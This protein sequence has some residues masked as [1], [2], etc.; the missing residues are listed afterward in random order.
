MLILGFVLI[1][2]F[3]LG[4]LAFFV[5][6]LDAVL[7]GHDLPTSREAVRAFNDLV[8]MHRPDA[9]VVYDLGAGRGT[10]ALRLNEIAPALQIHAVDK[11]PIRIWIA[12]LKARWLK[13]NV[14]FIRGDI[15]KADLHDAD[16]VYTYLWYSQMPP[17]ER[18]LKSVLKPGTL[19][20]TNTSYFPD[21]QPV[22]TRQTWPQHQDF[23]RLFVYRA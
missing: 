14:D 7:R 1:C 5:V 16:I 12:R 20:I 19:V 15:F 3:V 17:L 8:R 10:F 4:A 23:E 13:R 21:W 2:L 22:A 11:G 18:Y 9:R 6:S